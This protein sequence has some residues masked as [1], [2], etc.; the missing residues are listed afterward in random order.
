[1]DIAVKGAGNGGYCNEL[2]SGI[3]ALDGDFIELQATITWL[4]VRPNIPLGIF[5]D[6]TTML[7][8]T[9]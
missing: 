4:C 8:H 6:L 7:F 2:I 9:H 3:K 1:M 5:E